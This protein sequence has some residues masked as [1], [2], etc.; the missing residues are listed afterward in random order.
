[1][2]HGLTKPG[3]QCMTTVR[4]AGKRQTG[5]YEVASFGHHNPHFQAEFEVF[6]YLALVD[7]L[8]RMCMRIV[9]PNLADSNLVYD[10]F[11]L[12]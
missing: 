12:Q 8:H 3:C 11:D 6:E 1:M 2:G 7:V 4:I 9:H 5:H 10:A